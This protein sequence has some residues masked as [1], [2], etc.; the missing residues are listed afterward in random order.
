[1]STARRPTTPPPPS[2]ATSPAVRRRATRAHRTPTTAANQTLNIGGKSNA[3]STLNASAS[4]NTVNYNGTGAQ[5]AENTAYHH[6]RID[7]TV[8]PV[9]L[10][11]NIDVRGNLIN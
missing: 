6:L 11:G 3:I 10:Q 1:M 8:G 5:I 9:T 4:G 7:N 2:A